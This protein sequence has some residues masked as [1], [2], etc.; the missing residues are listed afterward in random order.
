MGLLGCNVTTYRVRHSSLDVLAAFASRGSAGL[1]AFH[2]GKV[3]EYMLVWLR[4]QGLATV[5]WEEKE[6][7]MKPE[8]SIGP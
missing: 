7:L 8:L 1:K 5:S 6:M 3:Y 2:A 4:L